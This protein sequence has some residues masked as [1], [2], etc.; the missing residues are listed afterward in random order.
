MECPVCGYEQ[1]STRRYCGR[2]GATLLIDRGD[3]S[4]GEITGPI[5]IGE[6]TPQASSAGFRVEGPALAL[7]AG[8]PGS[9]VFPLL[10]DPVSIGRTPHCELFLDD[11]TVSRDHA[12]IERGDDG[13]V[14]RDLGSLNGTY[15]NRRRIEGAEA[16]QDGDELQIGKFRLLFI[17]G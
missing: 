9:E 11:V 2:T 4:T 13:L 7:V 5:A 12:R 10:T 3:D 14:I 8:G 16:L 15:V 17:A 6:V 1:S